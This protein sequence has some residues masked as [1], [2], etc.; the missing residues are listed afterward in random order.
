MES[1][2]YV[3]FHHFFSDIA[4]L[5]GSAEAVTDI[6]KFLAYF[7][8][9]DMDFRLLSDFRVQNLKTYFEEHGG[10]SLVQGRG[11]LRC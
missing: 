6:E 8:A 3:L 5:V 11:C 7:F 10:A 9:F 2:K 4:P 1:G